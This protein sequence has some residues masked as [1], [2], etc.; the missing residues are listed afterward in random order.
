MSVVTYKRAIVPTLWPAGLGRVESGGFEL[1]V[2]S[3]WRFIPETFDEV[4]DWATV[5]AHQDEDDNRRRGNYHI[6]YQ[7]TVLPQDKHT[8]QIEVTV[9]LQGFLG[10]CNIG[11][12]G[13]WNRK[14]TSAVSA[15]QYLTLLSG[16]YTE[17]FEAQQAALDRLRLLVTTKWG[18]E[19]EETMAVNEGIRLRRPVFT[20]VRA[21]GPPVRAV[22]LGEATDPGAKARRLAKKWVVD[23]VIW[24]GV[25]RPNGDNMEVAPSSLQRGDFVE[26]TAFADVQVLRGKKGAG[27]I[28]HFAVMDVVKLWSVA[29]LKNLERQTQ[30][31]FAQSSDGAGPSAVEQMPSR[32]LIGGK[33]GNMM[34]VQ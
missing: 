8:K 12:L 28:V 31:T 4:C 2:S 15:V 16:G 25:R 10:D 26:V 20:M 9:V 34:D 29:D 19:V 30:L 27:T 24:T 32:F 7:P 11:M 22:G 18:A 13:N 21:Y 23:H 3:D 5:V 17:I 1:Q 33:R 6:V 14:E